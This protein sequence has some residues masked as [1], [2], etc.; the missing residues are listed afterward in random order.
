MLDYEI[1]KF[2]Q[3]CPFEA[4]FEKILIREADP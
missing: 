2:N 3:T 1:G 4:Y